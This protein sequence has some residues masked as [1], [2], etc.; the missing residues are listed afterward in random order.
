MKEQVQA[1]DTFAPFQ[2]ALNQ[3]WSKALESFK[4]IGSGLPAGGADWKTPQFSLSGDKLQAL[5]E[6][7]LA[8][9]S[10]LWREGINA[11]PVADRR[12]ADA[13]WSSNPLSAFAAAVYLLNARAPCSAW[14][15]RWK[16]TRKRPKAPTRSTG[17][18]RGA[19]FI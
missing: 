17:A 14:P 8:D 19:A 3:G 18:I 2:Q 9:A 10:A 6:Q 12:F 15:K 5:R 11:K 16:A 7:Y 13:A 4:S 1:A